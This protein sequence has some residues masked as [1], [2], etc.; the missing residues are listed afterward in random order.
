[1]LELIGWDVGMSTF[2]AVLLVVGALIIGVL[3]YL[4][5]EMTFGYEWAT[6]GLAA[7]WAATRQ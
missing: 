6:T 7:S 1:M 4:I 3:A 5:G 2:A